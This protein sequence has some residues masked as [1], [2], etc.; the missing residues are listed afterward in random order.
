[1]NRTF[2]SIAGA[3]G[4]LLFVT[5][6]I[7]GGLQFENY[8]HLSQ[9]I[10]ESYAIGTPHGLA[11]RF[12]FYLPSGL[13]LAL[14]AFSLKK[15]LGN[16]QPVNLGLTGVGVFY[17]L[18]TV[19]TSIF[20]C[21]AGCNPEMINPTI[22]QLIHNLTGMLTYLVTPISLAIIGLGLRS[23]KE[24][25]AL[26]LVSIACAGASFLFVLVLF[27]N[28]ADGFIG[29]YQRLIEGSI[30]VWFLVAAWHTRLAT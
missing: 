1:M 9:F 2:T 15:P 22:S 12:G 14:F 26:A 25:R 20:P 5:A 3:S 17:G 30:L 6:S 11:L 7:L 16:S 29:L 21:D 28:T 23:Q 8:S 24:H 18:T 27:S 10:S 4:V 19:V 13:L